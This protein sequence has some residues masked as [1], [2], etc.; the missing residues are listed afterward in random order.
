MSILVAQ[1]G[2]ANESFQ[3]DDNLEYKC[4]YS[5]M[6]VKFSEVT[7]VVKNGKVEGNAKINFHGK[8]TEES[9]TQVANGENEKVHLW[10]SK[11]K[12]DSS[13]EMVI[14]KSAYPDGDSKLINPHILY[15][16][17][18]WGTCEVRQL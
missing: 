14:Y 5:I 13:L 2:S 10:L 16:K 18:M 15:G 7:I 17:E 9:A 3:A 6:V 8:I 12:A 11:E 4:Q 1:S